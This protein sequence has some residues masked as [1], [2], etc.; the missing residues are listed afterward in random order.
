VGLVLFD[1]LDSDSLK[2]VVAATVIVSAKPNPVVDMHNA[3]R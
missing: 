1:K 2:V 3:A